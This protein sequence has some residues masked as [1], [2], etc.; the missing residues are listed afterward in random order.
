[1]SLGWEIISK[2]SWCAKQKMH[3]SG[4]NSLDSLSFIKMFLRLKIKKHFQ[5]HN[6]VSGMR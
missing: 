2:S 4:D 3:N 5:K 1:M 6:L